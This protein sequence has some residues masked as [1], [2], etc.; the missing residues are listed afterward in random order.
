M[1]YDYRILM[2]KD[3]DHRNRE[4]FT[5]YCEEL[6]EGACC[7]QG[8]TPPEAVEDFENNKRV[9][10]DTLKRMGMEIPKAY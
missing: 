8:E 10:L 9:Y 5:A 2:K 4:I 3:R 1:C 6:G 7:G